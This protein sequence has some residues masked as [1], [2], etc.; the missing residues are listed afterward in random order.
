MLEKLHKNVYSEAT[1]WFSEKVG[2]A[3]E[4]F[5]SKEFMKRLL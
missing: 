3:V 2:K 5:R 1:Y 4:E